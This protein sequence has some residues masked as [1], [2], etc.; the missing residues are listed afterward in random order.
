M[1]PEHEAEVYNIINWH[2]RRC[3]MKGALLGVAAGFALGLS[4][5]WAFAAPPCGPRA[6]VVAQLADQYGE[7]RRGM[8]LAG[9]GNGVVEVYVADTRTWTVVVTLPDGRACLLASG[10]GWEDLQDALPP[11]GDDL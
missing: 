7:S 8:G 9:D 2:G 6:L 3:F 11:E 10:I 1:T 5:K 4:T